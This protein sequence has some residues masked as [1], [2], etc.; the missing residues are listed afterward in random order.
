MTDTPLIKLE[1]LA[2]GFTNRE[3]LARPILRDVSLQVGAGESLGIVGESGSGK[4]TVVLAMM[5]YLK[6]GL[7]VF[8]GRVTFDG[9]DMFAISEEERTRL[10]GGSI[11]LIPQDAGQSLTPTLRIGD[12]INETL[13]LHTSLNANERREK[14]GELLHRVRLPSAEDIA[15]RYPHELSGGQQQRVAVAMGLGTGA[16]ALLLD[17]PTTGLDVTTQAHILEFLRSLAREIGVAMVYV[18]HDLGVIARVAD[19]IAVMYAGELVEQSDVRSLLNQPNHPY[20][21]ALLASIPRLGKKVIPAALDGFPPTVGENRQG[22]AFVERCHMARERCRETVP[23][24]V[25]VSLG[26]AK[27]FY[28]GPG[29]RDAIEGTPVVSTRQD[30]VAV[31][32][33]DMAISYHQPG[34]LDRLFGYDT[35]PDTVAGVAF[36]VNKGETLGLV[37]ESG[38]GKSTI[39]KALSGL[40]APKQGRILVEGTVI[41]NH[42]SDRTLDTI[43]PLQM[44]FQNAD[45]SLNPRHSVRE[46]LEAPLRLYFNLTDKERESRCEQLID[47]V[48]LPKRYLDRFPGHLS[49]GEK[50]RIGIARAFAAEP[51]LVLCDEVTSALDVSVQ[52]AALLLLKQLQEKRGAAYVYVSHDLAVVRAISDQIAVLYQGR[53]CETGPTEAVFEPPFH[54]YTEALLGAILEPD[55]DAVPRLLA[56][57]AIDRQPPEKGCPFQHRC[58]HRID[59]KCDELPPPEREPGNGHVIYCHLETEELQ[60]VQLSRQA[61]ANDCDL[62]P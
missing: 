25:K 13:K 54:P 55:P 57:D 9:H 21:R 26:H 49:G 58:L 40:K 16:K 38:C 6:P 47:S 17:E 31:E 3:G 48:R 14:I 62:F 15:R 42:V 59:G 2:L 52:A 33:E 34:L 24:M 43:K 45:S 1:S 50:Q 60:A 22:C 41:P 19:R 29:D 46:I 11:A 51:E 30:E 53:I 8:S 44:V 39:L 20:T 36:S 10:R 18:S 35:P 4:S 28:A 7:E 61:Q 5:G 56:D 12:Q 37:G 27:C 32:V 23:P